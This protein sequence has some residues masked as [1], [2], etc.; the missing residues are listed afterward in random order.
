MN[1]ALSRLAALRHAFP[2]TVST[3]VRR[4]AGYSL[5]S[6]R[7]AVASLQQDFFQPSRRDCIGSSPAYRE[8]TVEVRVDWPAVT[9]E[10]FAAL[11]SHDWSEA[12]VD[13]ACDGFL[14]TTVYA[15]PRGY[16][17]QDTVFAGLRDRLAAV[18]PN[19]T[20]EQLMDALQLIARWDT[21][22]PKDPVY[23]EFWSLFDKQC[24]ARY[25]NWSLNKLLLYMDHWYSMDLIKLSNFV[26]FSVR[27]LARKPSRYVLIKNA[28]RHV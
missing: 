9:D 2:K 14:S 12:T 23:C 16:Q 19:M 5:S 11:A 28:Y 18:L 25:K 24:T 8:T 15:A 17:L 4:T 1:R 20:D 3:V 10:R 13:E 27:K 7:P 6:G 21:K 22:N 26:W